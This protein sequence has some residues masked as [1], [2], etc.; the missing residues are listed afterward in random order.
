MSQV[1]FNH[2]TKLPSSKLGLSPAATVALRREGDNFV[3]GVA[4]CSQY[5][6]YSKKY[7]RE[8][9]LNRLEQRFRVTPIP[10]ELL[11]LEAEVGEKRMCLAFLYQISGSIAAKGRSWK[12]KVTKF[13]L[14]SKT[15]GKLVKMNAVKDSPDENTEGRA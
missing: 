8:I 3:Y 1:Y 14:D 13:N 15:T 5:D 4:I 10:A 9:A 7:G 2:T 11:K 12:R 6:N